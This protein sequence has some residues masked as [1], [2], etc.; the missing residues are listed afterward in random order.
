MPLR[1]SPPTAMALA[2]L[3][4]LH[5]H[6]HAQA[7]GD[8]P[9]KAGTRALPAVNVEASADAS[10]QGLAPAYTGGQV[11][12]GARLGILGRQDALETPFSITSYTRELIQNQQAASVGDV[13]LNDSAVRMARGFGNF[14]Q[15]YLIRGLPVFSDDMSYN[16]LFGLLP[17]QYLAAEFIER[18]EVLR[19]ANAF[20]N[21]AAPG[22]SGLGGAVNVVPKRAPNEPL[23]QATLGVQ[24]GGHAYAAADVG[25]R[26]SDDRLGLRLNLVRRDGDTAVDGESRELDAAALG[27][28][29]RDG[30]LRL[31]ADLGFQDHRMKASQPNVTIG[32][33][34]PIPDAPDASR[35]IAQPWTFSNE[36]DTF[37]TVRAEYDFRE[38]LTGWVAAGMRDGEESGRFANP[39][40]GTASGDFSAYRFDNIRRDRVAT[41]EVGLRGDLRTGAVRHRVSA[42]YAAYALDSRNAYAM[43]AFTAIGGNIHAPAMVPAPAADFFT[44]GNFADPL[45]TEKTR[46]ASFGLADVMSFMDER[47]L[48]TL[49]LR[50]QRIETSSFDYETG[51]RLSSY[52]DSAVTPVAGVL[53]R[54]DPG[55]SAYATYIEGL[56]KGDVAPATSG[57]EPVANAGE[58]LQ[59]Y[60]TKQVELGLKFDRGRLGGGIALFQSRKPMAG[61]DADRIFGIVGHQRNRGLE[62][63]AYGLAAPGWKVLGGLS[64]LDSDVE[65]RDAI[66]SPDVQANVGV[67]WSPSGWRGF[68]LEGRAIYTSSQYA[69]AASA[70]ELP[71]WTRVDLGARYV[72]P[73]GGRQL[74]TLRARIENLADRDYWASAGGYPGAG[75]LTL[76]APRTLVVSA[77]VDFF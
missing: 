36:R 57:G 75:Y 17:R 54:I 44:G 53:Y 50:H 49:G 51:D 31:S 28:D 16:G 67:E 25:R 42:S 68:A 20:L 8:G 4:L 72:L 40:V 71:S 9:G 59:P 26:L 64:L 34:L 70:Q 74:L 2:V 12:T 18:V 47:L 1:S 33:G 43:S 30:G 58:A 24:T 32:A 63:T 39:T 21:G 45:R 14:Q 77:S 66:G 27:V 55:L 76:A 62:M 48:V 73:I 38:G 10:A 35:S 29:W 3:F 11:A 5:P 52:S 46:T 7:A 23:T 15:V 19:G 41:G 65:G 60:R 69:D 22:G 56:V 13:L 61:V 6:A 37:G